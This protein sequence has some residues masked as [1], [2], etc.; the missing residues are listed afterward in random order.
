[1][2]G[3]DNADGAFGDVL[4]DLPEHGGPHEG[5]LDFASRLYGGHMGDVYVRL[6]HDLFAYLRGE[7]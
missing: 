1:M 5:F 2:L 7:D 3:M 4:L 6:L